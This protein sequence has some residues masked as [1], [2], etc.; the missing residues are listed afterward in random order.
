MHV[1]KLTL[2]DVFVEAVLPD[3][4]LCKKPLTHDRWDVLDLHNAFVQH[5]N[6]RF[7]VKVL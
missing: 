7:R 6:Y 4:Q 5:I 2:T 1:S 3:R